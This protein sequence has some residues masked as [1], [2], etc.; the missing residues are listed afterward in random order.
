MLLLW[1]VMCSCLIHIQVSYQPGKCMYDV[2]TPGED[3]SGKNV[4]WNNIINF[5]PRTRMWLPRKQ[6]EEDRVNVRPTLSIDQVR[7]RESESYFCNLPSFKILS[8]LSTL[9]LSFIICKM[10]I[11]I[12]K[13]PKVSWRINGDN[14]KRSA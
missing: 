11:I 12:I 8:T 6:G 3:S 9:L 14:C 1:L 5:R 4:F 7:R 2:R 10:G 13:I